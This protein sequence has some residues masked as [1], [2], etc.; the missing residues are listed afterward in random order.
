MQ[1]K[2]DLTSV[3]PGRLAALY[4]LTPAPTPVSGEVGLGLSSRICTS[5]KGLGLLGLL[6]QNRFP[7]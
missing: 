4:S 6:A 3:S 1:L 2:L 5:N 7:D